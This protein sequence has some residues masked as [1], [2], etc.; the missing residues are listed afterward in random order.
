MALR[1]LDPKGGIRR[2]RKKARERLAEGNLTISWSCSYV[3]PTVCKITDLSSPMRPF[4]KLHRSHS[5][6]YMDRL[7]F[8]AKL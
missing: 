6:E 3:L 8:F 2:R 1:E 7:R 4:I 5:V